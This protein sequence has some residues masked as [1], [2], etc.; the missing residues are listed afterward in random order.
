MN[1]EM[2]NY[3]CKKYNIN[4]KSAKE[5]DTSKD[6]YRLNIILDNKYVIRINDQKVMTEDRLSEIQ[7]LI[8]RYNSIGIYV[9]N[10]LMNS[11]G[12]YSIMIDDLICY[13]S[14]YGN[15]PV[16]EEIDIDYDTLKREA[17]AHLG[18]FASKY[19]G[20]DLSKNKSMWSIIDLSILDIDIDEKQENINNLVKALSDIGETSLANSINSFNKKNRNDILKV[21]DK[22]PRCMYQ[23]DLNDANILMKDNHFYGLIDFNLSGTDVNINCFLSE[24]NKWLEESDFDKY[25]PQELFDEM[26]NYQND[27]MDIILQ[28][29][30]LNEI[31]KQV[32]ENYRNIILLAQYPSVCLYIDLLNSQYKDKV[33]ALINLI[34]NRKKE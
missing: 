25:T 27:L 13:V 8:G 30:K 32:L 1:Y 9:P 3:I 22:L 6:D 12:K 11:D 14:E 28:H 16:A 17:V 2:L 10:Y 24:T 7:R 33:L 5:I 31:E 4:Y 19:T 20:Y 15:Y 29:Y 23:G 21:F 18:L 34:I 26:I